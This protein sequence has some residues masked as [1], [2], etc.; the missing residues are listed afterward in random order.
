VSLVYTAPSENTVKFTT[1]GLLMVTAGTPAT[2]K[3]VKAELL[4]DA[5]SFAAIA[6]DAAIFALTAVLV[7]GVVAAGALPPPPPP[8]PAMASD[9]SRAVPHRNNEVFM[10]LI[11][12]NC[13]NICIVVQC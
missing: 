11:L 3:A 6:P 5:V 10:F 2:S 1:G 7:P 13:L 9:A 8:Q 4:L 12:Y